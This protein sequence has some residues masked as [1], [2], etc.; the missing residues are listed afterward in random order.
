[1]VDNRLSQ[2]PVGELRIESVGNSIPGNGN[3]V[4]RGPRARD[5]EVLRYSQRAAGLAGGAMVRVLDAEC[6]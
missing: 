3:H 5:A 2:S 1:M 6:S 4:C